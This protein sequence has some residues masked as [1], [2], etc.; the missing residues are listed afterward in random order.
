MASSPALFRVA[1]ALGALL[2]LVSF[3]R[4]RGVP[5]KPTSTTRSADSR[6]CLFR[7]PA[8]FQD[9]HDGDRKVVTEAG[10]TLL[11]KPFDTTQNWEVRSVLDKTH[12]NATVDF[13]VKGKPSP[14][15]VALLA[16]IWVS[17]RA[18]TDDEEAKDTIEFTDPSV[19]LEVE[20]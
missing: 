8:V 10:D 13:R 4:L 6:P 20:K 11:I 5:T 12:C 9:M 18:N 7:S 3:A 17:S 16:T 14:P 1:L 2:F 19:F 15:P